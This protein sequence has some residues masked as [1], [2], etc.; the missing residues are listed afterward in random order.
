VCSLQRAERQTTKSCTGRSHGRQA[1]LHPSP[2]RATLD[3]RHS[4]RRLGAQH[5]RLEDA[6]PGFN[7]QASPRSWDGQSQPEIARFPLLCAFAGTL[8]DFS[9]P[10]TRFL[11]TAFHAEWDRRV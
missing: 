10:S 7:A 6:S 11:F 8:L 9:S 4:H 1:A 2:R 5:L 3:P